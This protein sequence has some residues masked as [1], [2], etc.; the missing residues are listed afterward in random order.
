MHRPVQ[1][2]P[3][4]AWPNVT[5][6]HLLDRMRTHRYAV[7]SS[8]AATGAPQSAVVGVA[9]TD[10]F[11]IVFDTLASSRKWVNLS[12]DPRVA[13]VMGSVLPDASWSVQVEGVVDEPLG[14]E[15]E[16]L[17]R[18][19]LAVFPDGAERQSWPGLT[20]VRVRPRWI[21]ATDYTAVPPDIVEFDAAALR[22]MS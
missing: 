12:R 5:R 21:R 9:V 10:A 17:V 16:A 1:V 18:A 20:Y 6:A 15:R 2:Q 22:Q 8:V 19:Y 3:R 7:Q 11:E 13:F 4:H 14:D